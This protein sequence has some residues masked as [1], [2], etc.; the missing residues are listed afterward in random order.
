MSH[1]QHPQQHLEHFVLTT[2]VKYPEW[3]ADATAVLAAA[4]AQVHRRATQHG[5]VVQGRP[6]E[7]VEDLHD[8]RRVR[9]TLSVDALPEQRP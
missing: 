7:R 3:A 8:A 5:L 1:P 6:S 4:H 2:V 9:I